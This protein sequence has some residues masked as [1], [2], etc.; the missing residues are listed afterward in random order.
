[1]SFTYRIKVH[2]PDGTLRDTYTPSD[3][4]G[5]LANF[6]IDPIGICGDANFNVLPQE[7][8]ILPRDIVLLETSD[9]GTTFTPL[10]LGMVVQAPNP[11]AYELSAVR[12]VGL[13]QRF[14]EINVELARVST[15]D[16]AAMFTAAVNSITL[17]PLVTFASG[18]APT[19]GFQLGDR[20]PKFESLGELADALA[21]TVGSFVVATGTYVY[22][23]KTFAASS[24][25]PQVRWG[26]TATGALVFRRSVAAPL[27]RS[28]TA[29]DV[30]LEWLDVEVEEFVNSVDLV[31]GSAFDL[32]LFK[33]A[34]V[35]PTFGLGGQFEPDPLP[36]VRRFDAA[37][38]TGAT[39][40]GKVVV[41]PDP[42]AIMT[43]TPQLGLDTDPDLW[44][45]LDRAVNNNDND[46]ANKDGPA[47]MEVRARS[48]NSPTTRQGDGFGQGILTIRYSSLEDIEFQMEVANDVLGGKFLVGVLPATGD[49]DRVQTVGLLVAQ[50]KE[51]GLEGTIPYA[52]NS[53]LELFTEGDVRIWSIRAFAPDVDRGATRDRRF[54][55]AFFTRLSTG[56]SS[57][58]QIGLQP[59]AGEMTITPVIGGA[60]TSFVERVTYSITRARGAETT[61]Y[62]DQAFLAG[63]EAQRV[64]LERLAQRAVRN[65]GSRR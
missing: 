51:V 34:R 58:R 28:E 38:V 8:E 52:L 33:V 59:F 56:V 23:G 5:D 24:T 64:L 48:F 41:V 2:Q 46:F 30:D 37:G 14:Y 43:Q 61:F 36:I 62:L 11:R 40:A 50:P 35:V 20:Y 26:V 32:Q 27:A 4:L 45:N 63:E 65:E 25:V 16:V 39:R 15:A 55:E 42:L 7:V 44:T 47:F 60:F 10:Y 31:Y 3:E 54:A 12:C 1:M 6:D 22:D 21:E 57:V 49:L 18:N 9:D 53:T 19:T 17:P 13:K 29:P